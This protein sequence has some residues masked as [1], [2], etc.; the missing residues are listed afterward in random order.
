V[1]RPSALSVVTIAPE[2]VRL[3]IKAIDSAPTPTPTEE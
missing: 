3:S 2:K 1:H